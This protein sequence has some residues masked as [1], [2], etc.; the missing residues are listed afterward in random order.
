LFFPC[1]AF[2]N[3]EDRHE[4][5]DGERFAAL[6]KPVT[7]PLEISR[8]VKFSGRSSQSPNAANRRR[9]EIS[10]NPY[11]GATDFFGQRQN[12]MHFDNACARD[13]IGHVAS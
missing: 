6:A 7:N 10:R 8:W 3:R 13:P 4:R 5:I 9:L 11:R 2:Y 12:G 1:A